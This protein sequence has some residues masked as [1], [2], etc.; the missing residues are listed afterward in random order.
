M[1]RLLCLS[2]MISIFFLPL[3]LFFFALVRSRYGFL[4]FSQAA[5]PFLPGSRFAAAKAASAASAMLKDIV[6]ACDAARQSFCRR[7]AL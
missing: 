2:F 7:A 4:P 5:M 3:L 1:P 6:S